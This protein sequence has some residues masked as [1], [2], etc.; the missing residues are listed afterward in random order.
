MLTWGGILSC[1]ALPAG[2]PCLESPLPAH[3][4]FEYAGRAFSDS[5]ISRGG[6]KPAAAVFGPH[7]RPAGPAG[8]PKRHRG[9]LW[10]GSTG[11]E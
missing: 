5:L 6:G 7:L 11:P 8:Q 10:S 1:W 9:V 2:P 4:Q 3:I